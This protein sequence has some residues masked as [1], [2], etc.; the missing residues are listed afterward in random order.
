MAVPQPLKQFVSL[1]E[2]ELCNTNNFNPYTRTPPNDWTHPNEMMDNPHTWPVLSPTSILFWNDNGEEE[3]FQIPAAPSSPRPLSEYSLVQTPAFPPIPRQ[4]FMQSP[5]PPRRT[6]RELMPPPPPG[7]IKRNES[8]NIPTNDG[9]VAESSARKSSQPGSMLLPPPGPI[10]RT[11]SNGFARGGTV[12]GR[13]GKQPAKS[14]S[15]SPPKRTISPGRMTERQQLARAKQASLEEAAALRAANGND[16]PPTWT[17]SDEDEDDMPLKSRRR[18]KATSPLLS[19]SPPP[20]SASPPPR[21]AA[22]RKRKPSASLDE[23]EVDFKPLRA[24][25]S[26]DGSDY[27]AAPS[28]K[29]RRKETNVG[30][31]SRSAGPASTATPRTAT[32]ARPPNPPGPPPSAVYADGTAPIPAGIQTLVQQI[33]DIAAIGSHPRGFPQRT[34]LRAMPSGIRDLDRRY[35]YLL[36]RSD[37]YAWY[38]DTRLFGRDWWV[39]L[40]GSG[41]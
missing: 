14:A 22:S 1:K 34:K 8:N 9:P 25:D 26:D 31:S 6:Q 16:M 12:A 7:P 39:H 29:R 10:K 41:N 28:K 18:R 20:L 17:Q 32:T 13:L 35:G 24:D 33:R 11:E 38:G 4:V 30:N 27:E 3:M 5:P 15:R 2:I 19:A 21:P 36:A 37:L 40:V 23:G